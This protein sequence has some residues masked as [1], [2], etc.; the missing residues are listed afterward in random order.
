ME[1][2]RL[3]AKLENNLIRKNGGWIK[4]IRSLSEDM[5]LNV[6]NFTHVPVSV[7]MG[8]MTEKNKQ[9]GETK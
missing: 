2:S 9:N 6:N 5:D 8:R 3:P 4:I 7:V 1:H